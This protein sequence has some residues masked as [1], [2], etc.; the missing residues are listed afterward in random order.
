MCGSSAPGRSLIFVLINVSMPKA[1]AEALQPC[2]AA[3][4]GWW[5]VDYAPWGPKAWASAAAVSTWHVKHIWKRRCALIG[6]FRCVRA[7]HTLM[8]SREWTS[9]GF[10]TIGTS[11]Q[12]PE[13]WLSRPINAKNNHVWAVHTR[14]CRMTSRPAA[15]IAWLGRQFWQPVVRIGE[16]K[17]PGPL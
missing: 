11:G 5:A 3:P 6:W 8:C 10:G 12:F 4:V 15:A 1:G 9:H 14:H 17:N 2:A 13:A 16:A 7:M